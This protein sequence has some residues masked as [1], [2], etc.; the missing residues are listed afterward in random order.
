MVGCT[1][2][3]AA[4]TAVLASQ[5]APSICSSVCPAK[6]K[7]GIATAGSHRAG[8]QIHRASDVG[9]GR[10]GSGQR[11]HEGA[12]VSALEERGSRLDLVPPMS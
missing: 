7:R 6:Q 10:W 9:P 11:K 2:E 4:G 1:Q 12:G 3:K 8:G 5:Q